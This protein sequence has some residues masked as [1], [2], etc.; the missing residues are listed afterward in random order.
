MLARYKALCIDAVGSVASQRF[1]AVALGL[2]PEQR[3]DNLLLTGEISQQ[4]VWINEVPEAKTAK[5]RVHLDVNVASIAELVALGATVLADQQA[6]TVMA[7][8]DGQEFCAFVRA[9]PGEYRLYE[10]VL[11]SPD[12][13]AIVDWWAAVLGGESDENDDSA[14]LEEVPWLPF[15]SLVFSRVDE[16]KRLKNRVHFDVDVAELQPLL[17]H[18]A[19][20]LRPRGGDIDWWVLADPD[21]NEFCA[22]L[23]E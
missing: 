20:L 8:P 21:G 9:D 2:A 23:P 13:R 14:W 7:D 3:R 19:T 16:L 12:P 22:F 5:N 6:W 18:G 17:D 15:E 11:D 10:L 1:W 4:R